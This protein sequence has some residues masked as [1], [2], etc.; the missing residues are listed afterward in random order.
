VGRS[1]ELAVLN[2]HGFVLGGNSTLCYGPAGGRTQRD[3][4][5]VPAKVCYLLLLAG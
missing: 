3:V 4:E 2:V 5:S 1:V